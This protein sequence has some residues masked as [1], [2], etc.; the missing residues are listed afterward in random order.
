MCKTTALLCGISFL[1]AGHPHLFLL[2]SSEDEGYHRSRKIV[3]KALAE[4]IAH[5]KLHRDDLPK[6]SLETA[7]A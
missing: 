7:Y 1:T 2:S 5:R 4:L 3:S 6:H